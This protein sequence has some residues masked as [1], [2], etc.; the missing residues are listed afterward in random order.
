[1]RA[2]P[3]AEGVL[4][5]AV[6]GLLACDVA[7]GPRRQSTYPFDLAATGLVFHWPTDRLPVRV[8]VDPAAGPVRAYV[9]DGLQEWAAVF[10]YGEF[11][12]VLVW[13]PAQADVLVEVNGA[14]P[15][16]VPRTNDPPVGACSGVTS[17]DRTPDNRLTGPFRVTLTWDGR[18]SATDVAN[19]LH[20]VAAHELG[21]TIGLLQHSSS[22]LDLMF[23]FP[24]VASPSPTDRATVEILYHTPATLAPAARPE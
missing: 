12:G 23:A 14:T 16:D 21:H 3:L 17:N 15:P 9:S 18:F 8:W 20:R 19:C 11:R 22:T 6:C 7:T 1:M 24:E 5:V 13:D 2:R 10:L 4:L